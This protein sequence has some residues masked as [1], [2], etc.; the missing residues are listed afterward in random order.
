VSDAPPAATHKVLDEKR[1][2]AARDDFP[3]AATIFRPKG[4]EPDQVVIVTCAMAV[5]RGFYEPYARFLASNGCAVFTFDYRGI[6][7]SLTEPIARSR[8]TLRDW[9]E[10]DIPAVIDAARAEFPGK[11]VKLVGHSIGAQLL[12]MVDNVDQLDAVCTVTAQ[13]GY[14]RNYPFL[15]AVA[16]AA[17]WYLLVPIITAV[18]SYF[19]AKK[20]RFG[21][22][23]PKGVA[24]GWGTFCRSPHYL[25]TPEGKP[26]HAGYEAYE[27]PLRVYCFADDTIAPEPLV[28]ALHRYFTNTRAEVRHIDPKSVNARSIGHMGF[29]FP[30]FKG[31]LWKEQL[32]WLTS[33]VRRAPA[34]RPAAAAAAV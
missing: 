25:V 8:A 4:A 31:T 29:F 19:P 6:G 24:R 9:G 3:L 13:H 26:A 30:K 10:K 15:R 21:E 17:L 12:G 32:E 18:L 5:R 14:W 23:L 1:T 27:G 34:D 33:D 2:I 28:A 16:F 11:K 7:G 22:D 20:L